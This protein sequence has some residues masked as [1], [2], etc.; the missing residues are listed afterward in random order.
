MKIDTKAPGATM[1]APAAIVRG[2]VALSST[3]TEPSPPAASGIGSVSYQWIPNAADPSVL[4]NW[5][6]TA[7][8]WDTSSLADGPY[9]V[10]VKAIDNAGNG[11]LSPHAT[12]CVDN[13]APVTA[14]D[15]P[16]GSRASDVVV[17]LTAND[18][19][20]CGGVATEYSLDGGATWQPGSSVSILAPA[21]HSNDGTHTVKYR[22]ADAA[23]NQEAA[24]SFTVVIDTTAPS[25]G[26]AVDPGSFLRG[27]VTL[28]ASP[29]DPDVE[30]VRW[31]YRPAASSGAFTTIGTDSS[32]PFSVDWDTTAGVPDGAYSVQLVVTDTAGNSST[33]PLSPK[34]VD[35][36]L[37]TGSLTAP[38]DGAVV[39]GTIAFSA[40]ASDA[41]AGVQSVALQVKGAGAGA[42][43]TVATDTTA[44][45]STGFNSTG[46][47]DGPAELRALVTDFAGNV[48]V[49]AIRTVTV[50]NDAPVVT[51][52]DPGADVAGTIAL[53]ASSSGDT[54]SV[55]FERQTGAG[56][57]AFANDSS[58]P[59]QAT[60]DTTTVP[61]GN[62]VLRAVATDV[63]LNTGQSAPRTTRVDNTGPA[64]ALTSPA[65]GATVGGP[66]VALAPA[67][68]T[69]GS[70]SPPS[71]SRS[72]PRPRRAPG[73]T[74]RPT[75]ARPTARRWTQRRSRAA[76]TTCAC[77][78]R[79]PSATRPSPPRC[80]SP[81]TR[82]LPG[83]RSTRSTRSSPARICSAPRSPARAQRACSSS[84]GSGAAPGTRSTRT[85]ARRS[86]PPS[87]PASSR[88]APST[89]GRRSPTASGTPRTSSPPGS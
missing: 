24:K 55:D 8:S 75:P 3:V 6:D 82:R 19:T 69:P 26:G 18:G 59:F 35:N 86:R 87:T 16:S 47:P 27:T 52:S 62:L 25:G 1:T 44:P 58:A 73:R 66:S 20:G 41:T 57:V 7:A 29:S 68:P 71:S 54:T 42:F 79:T 46:V 70:A 31:E 15:A 49:T 33:F 78:R 40:N 5:T 4:A 28:T 13:H 77:S 17:T 32:A 88:T 12:T 34:T 38:A 51:L 63:G 22:S 61:D 50:D 74:S 80:S 56:W 30:S 2:T 83:W 43:T 72:G 37:P 45:Y 23:T 85:R 89:S 9:K 53:T 39:G 21:D 60:F 10:R 36:T 64:S 48:F 67:R 14:D 11:V 81:S 65:A 76:T 84:T